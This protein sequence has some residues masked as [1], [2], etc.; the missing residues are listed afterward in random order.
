MKAIVSEFHTDFYPTKEEVK[1]LC[2]P[3]QGADT[4]IWL[5][6]GNFVLECCCNHRPPYIVERW[7]KGE[8][9]AKRD[10]CDKVN[11]FKPMELGEVVF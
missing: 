11:S 3:G 2:R 10:G 4:C 7:I 1:E 6:M 8:T 9:T 5:I